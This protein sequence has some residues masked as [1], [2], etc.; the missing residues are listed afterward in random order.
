[1]IKKLFLFVLIIL[2]IDLLFKLI[3]FSV[4]FANESPFE[5]K[6]IKLYILTIE[7]LLYTTPKIKNKNQR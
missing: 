5:Y 7:N 3:H 6:L 2:V 4:L 1:M